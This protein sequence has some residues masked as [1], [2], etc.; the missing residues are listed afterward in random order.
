MSCYTRWLYCSYQLICNTC[1]RSY[2][3]Q[4][5]RNLK[6]RF[7]EH[8]RYVKNN[9]PQSAYALHILNCRHE[10][11]NINDTIT[12]LKHINNPSLLL[13]YEQMYIQLF[14]RNNQLIPEQ[15]PNEQKP[16]FQLLYNR[17]H[18]SHPT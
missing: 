16:M 12:L 9:D 5:R 6:S 10:Y 11:G 15:H 2:I 14:H 1:Q 4:S 13:S 7:Q 8:A 3:G 18:T 17:Y